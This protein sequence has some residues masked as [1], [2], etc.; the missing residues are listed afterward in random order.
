MYLLTMLAFGCGRLGFVENDPNGCPRSLALMPAGDGAGTS[1]DP[2]RVCS[3]AQLSAVLSHADGLTATIVLDGD[4]DFAGV[5]FD[6]IGSLDA[7]FIGRIDG[8]GRTIS[9][10]TITGRPGQPAGFVNVGVTA[11]L[12]NLTLDKVS[13]VGGESVGA[14]VGFCERSQLRDIVVTGA[15]VRGEKSVGALAGEAWECQS[16]DVALAGKVEGTV[17]SVGGITGGTG[18]SAYMAVEFAPTGAASAS[19]P[20]TIGYAA[21]RGPVSHIFTFSGRGT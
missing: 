13:V 3:P 2:Y 6:G 19:A 9:N 17:E 20:V 11:Q 16:F 5:A 4:L 12:A 7:P 15:D 14:V 10:L 8:N 21:G 18:S 1:D